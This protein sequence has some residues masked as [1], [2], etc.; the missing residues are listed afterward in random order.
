MTPLSAARLDRLV[1]QNWRAR[2]VKALLE[3]APWRYALLVRVAHMLLAIKNYGLS[4]AGLRQ[5]A[6]ERGLRGVTR[7][8]WASFLPASIAL[9]V[10]YSGCLP[11][12]VLNLWLRGPLCRRPAL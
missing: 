7:T 2:R 10:E 12:A 3:D 11:T 6:R 4:A 1:Q 5:G 9:R 8:P